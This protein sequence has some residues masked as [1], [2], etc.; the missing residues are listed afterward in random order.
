MTTWNFD[1]DA[2]PR[3]KHEVRTRKGKDGSETEFNHF[4]PARIIAASSDG[5]TVTA[6]NWLP[7]QGRWNMFN[8]D[9]PP[10][11]WAPWPEHPSQEP[12]P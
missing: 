8:K 2:A 4:V 10:I 11:A 12:T 5:V 7:E 3:G 1:M 6:S 9:A